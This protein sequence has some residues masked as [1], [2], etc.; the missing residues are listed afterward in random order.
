M[1]ATQHDVRFLLLQV[2]NGDDPMRDQEVRCF[3]R[4]FRCDTGQI[5]VL[6]LLRGAPTLD[7]LRSCDAALLGGSGDY[8]VVEGGPWL[9]AALAAMRELVECSKPT[10]ASCWGF[11]AMAKALGG[12]VVTD[13][14]RAELG[15]VLVRQTEAAKSD[16]VFSN[17]TEHFLAQMGHQDVVT[18]LPADAVLLA[19]NDRVEHQAFRLKNKPIYCTQFHPELDRRALVERVEAYPQYV[20]QIAGVSVAQFE[21]EHCHET[22]TAEQL[23]RDFVDKCVVV[24]ESAG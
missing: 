19:S 16:P 21:A 23:L 12:E 15:S 10:F 3:A 24:E 11:Q 14:S 5:Q 17:A 2:R 1:K 7:E 22:P 20:K 18:K 6:D 4:A 8:S 9:A 13:P